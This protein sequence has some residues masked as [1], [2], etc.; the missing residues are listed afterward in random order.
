M[1]NIWTGLIGG[2]KSYGAVDSMLKYIASGGVCVTNLP[3]KLDPWYCRYPIY[4]KRFKGHYRGL[5]HDICKNCENRYP[6]CG[7]INALGIREVLRRYYGWELQDGQLIYLDNEDLKSE[8]LVDLIPRGDSDLPIQIWIDEAGDFF[9]TKDARSAD[10]TFLS[11]LKHSRHLNVD[12]FFIIQRFKELNDRIRNQAHYVYKS[13][14]I[15]E[16]EIPGLGKIL[17]WVPFF[18]KNIRLFKY[19]RSNFDTARPQPVFMC[20]I[21]K[22]YQIFSCYETE[23]LH[24][25][26]FANMQKIKNNFAIDGKIKKKT[27]YSNVL[28]F[29]NRPFFYG[30]IYGLIYVFS[31]EIVV[32]FIKLLKL[33]GF[34]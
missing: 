25:D 9:D 3:I 28:D 2:G 6:G 10:Q 8:K 13:V 26:Y 29:L 24:T 19:N 5:T 12:F 30:I 22:R 1:I 16:F 34:I 17:H 14:N 15:G 18:N 33:K 21:F 20:W 32:D 27:D 7:S 4:F 11:L 23:S 31:V